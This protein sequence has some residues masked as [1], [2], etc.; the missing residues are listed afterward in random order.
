MRLKG[1]FKGRYPA[2][3]VEELR[4]VLVVEPLVVSSG[5][6]SVHLYEAPV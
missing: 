2:L 1:E 6:E 3:D 4:Q 5:E